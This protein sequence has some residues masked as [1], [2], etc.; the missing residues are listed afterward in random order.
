MKGIEGRPYEYPQSF[1]TF[2]KILHDFIQ[3]RYRQLKG[4]VRALSKHI[5]KIKA[6]SFS[7]IRRAGDILPTMNGGASHE[8]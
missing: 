6:P 7:Q 1:M 2:L 8:E 5:P 3:I 4:F